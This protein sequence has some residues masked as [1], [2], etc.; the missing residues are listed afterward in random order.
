MGGASWTGCLWTQASSLQPPTFPPSARSTCVFVAAN[1]TATS[2]S[3]RKSIRTSWPPI[4]RAD[5]SP[6]TSAIAS[7]IGT[8]SPPAI[9]PLPDSPAAL[10]QDGLRRT[11]TLGP[12]SRRL[13]RGKR[14]SGVARSRISRSDRGRGHIAACGSLA[15]PVRRNGAPASR[16]GRRRASQFTGSRNACTRDFP[17]KILFRHLFAS[18]GSVRRRRRNHYGPGPQPGVRILL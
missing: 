12:I 15:R 3:H 8:S 17:R 4:P 18:R 13:F 14:G 16:D 10:S 1:S 9:T 5:T 6:L 2:I 11:L 7:L